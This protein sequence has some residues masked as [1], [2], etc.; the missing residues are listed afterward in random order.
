[1]N[2]SLKILIIAAWLTFV[3]LTGRA[4]ENAI[5]FGI[6]PYANPSVIFENFKPLADYLSN[7]IGITVRI[8]IASNYVRHIINLGTGKIDIGYAGPSPYVKIRD[9]FGTIEPLAKIKMKND[10]ND[11]MVI[12]TH[13]NSGIEKL[14]DLKSKTFVFGNHQSFGSHF[15]SRYILSKNGIQLK[16]LMGYD[17][18]T[19]HDN[20]VLSVLH[21]DFEAGGMRE[22]IYL[23]HQDGSLKIIYGPISIPPH[24]I[25]SRSSL[26]EDIKRKI[27]HALLRL[28]DPSVLASINMSMEG[29]LPV[30][31]SEFDPAREVINYMESR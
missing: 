25:V 14:A 21:E 26:A 23:K 4:S 10:V 1:M 9:K 20:V 3:P 29:F 28:K 15:M 30:S 7:Q 8:T 6:N 24:V 31:D 11:R 22:D 19:S 2:I 16:D 18:A 27:R 13:K 17:C 12:V 5:S